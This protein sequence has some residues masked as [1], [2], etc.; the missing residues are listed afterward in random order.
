MTRWLDDPVAVYRTTDR[1]LRVAGP[2]S[3]PWLNSLL[4][5][6]LRS[7]AA[8]VGRYALLLSAQGGVVSDL[9]VVEPA[10]QASDSLALIIPSSHAPVVWTTLNRYL[11]NEPVTLSF[12][13]AVCVVTVQ[14]PRGRAVLDRLP[15]AACYETSRLDKGGFDLLVPT[16]QIGAAISVLSSAAAQLGGG[17]L[18]AP[19][20][21][22]GRVA[23][24]VPQVGIDFDEGTSPHEAG[25][26]ER[27]VSL[28]KGCY[29]GQ[30]RVAKQFRQGGLERRLTQ[31]GIEG[32]DRTAEGSEV[33]DTA[34]ATIG[35]VTSVG[36]RAAE[37]SARILALAYVAPAFAEVGAPVRVEGRAAQVRRVVGRGELAT[38]PANA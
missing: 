23:L 3:R 13:D 16:S 36:N 1:V 4:T 9:W 11:L 17:T 12:D 26:V 15:G 24:G 8:N 14:G 10:N 25:L 29:L 32:A 37:G 5:I 7:T 18:S 33:H 20:W 30:Q 34:G 38:P 31:L 21:S 22:S 28:T 19:D 27:A 2:G 6:D 35:R